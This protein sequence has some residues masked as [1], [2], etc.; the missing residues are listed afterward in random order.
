MIQA[1]NSNKYGAY[2][3]VCKNIVLKDMKINKHRLDTELEKQAELFLNYALEWVNASD[4]VSKI[5]EKLE[6]TKAK[7]DKEIRSKPTKF[8]LGEKI[9]ETGIKASLTLHPKV[10]KANEDLLDCIKSEKIYQIIKEAFGHKKKALEKLVEL[11]LAG[12]YGNPK[13]PKEHKEVRQK[14]SSKKI[15]KALNKNSRLKKPGR[16]E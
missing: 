4:K 10:I 16:S 2:L 12:Y 5:K 8:N 15:K 6:L 13:E 3:N 14:D 9:T 1:T 7:A 11:T